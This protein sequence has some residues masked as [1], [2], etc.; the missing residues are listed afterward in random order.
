M[1]WL[2]ASPTR[3]IFRRTRN[4]PKSAHA[5]ATSAPVIR[6]MREYC[7]SAFMTAPPWFVESGG[8]AGLPWDGAAPPPTRE[9]FRAAGRAPCPRRR[10]ARDR[11]ADRAGGPGTAPTDD[12]CAAHG[13]PL[14]A[15]RR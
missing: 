7:K 14:L 5:A 4:V 10:G 13:P 1:A 12:G 11:R 6:R 15:P 9:R 2:M 3:D 8:R